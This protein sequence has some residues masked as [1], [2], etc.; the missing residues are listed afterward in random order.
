V[1]AVEAL[2]GPGEVVVLSADA[3]GVTK[4]AWAIDEAS[5]TRAR[6]AWDVAV[7]APRLAWSG[8]PSCTLSVDEPRVEAQ[9]NAGPL[10]WWANVPRLLSYFSSFGD[11]AWRDAR[12]ESRGLGVLER[13]WGGD[14]P[15]DVAALAPKRWHWDVLRTDDGAVYA[16]LSVRG[17]G[18]R[19]ERPA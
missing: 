5:C 9:A 8:F 1:S 3:R 15:V 16:G 12:G 4:H 7:A 6:G 13:A 11:V 17:A 18:L 2:D 14:A 19:T 10:G